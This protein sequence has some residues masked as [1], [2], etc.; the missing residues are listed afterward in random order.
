[1]VW[2]Q[3]KQNLMVLLTFDLSDNPNEVYF[4]VLLNF[5]QEVVNKPIM[6]FDFR[7]DDNQDGVFVEGAE[8]AYSIEIKD[9]D[10]GWH[11]ISIKYSDLQTLYNGEPIAA[12]GNDI[13]E[14][15]L[16]HTLR[17]LFLA[18]QGNGYSEAH[19][20]YMIFTQGQPLNP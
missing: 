6:L 4:N 13:M 3:L 16:I 11:L 12:D 19:M 17:V 9:L 7:E 15:H 5:P 2:P 14:P 20:D 8:D 18:P 1:M 10:P